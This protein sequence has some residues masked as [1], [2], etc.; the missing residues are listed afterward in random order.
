MSHLLDELLAVE[1][2]IG[3]CW[4]GNLRWLL[5]ANDKLIAT[6]LDLDRDTRLSPSPITTAEIAPH[7]DVHFITHEHGDPFSEPT[8]RLLA[9]SGVCRFVLPANCF[10]KAHAIGIPESPWQYPTTG[11]RANRHESPSM[12]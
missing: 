12:S 10:E 9:K 7:L 1:K 2:G 11:R 6:D 8:C 4:L 5:R 3:I